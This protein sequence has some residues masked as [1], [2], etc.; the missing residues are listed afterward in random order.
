MKQENDMDIRTEKFS[1]AEF[2][3]LERYENGRI[4]DLSNIFLLLTD[5][6]VAQLHSDDWSYY[7]ELQEE[8]VYELSFFA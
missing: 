4:M 1:T 3:T 5:G 8:L 7:H 6:Q 2:L